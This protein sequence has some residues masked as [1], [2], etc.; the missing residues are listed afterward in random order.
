MS[1]QAQRSS[2]PRV[3]LLA[4]SL[5]DTLEAAGITVLDPFRVKDMMRAAS[6]GLNPHT[7]SRL[8]DEMVEAGAT[9]KYPVWTEF[10]YD[11]YCG[12]QP[13]YLNYGGSPPREVSEKIDK[14][15][16]LIP[17]TQVIVHTIPEDPY[18]EVVVGD[19]R[20]WVA[21]WSPAYQVCVV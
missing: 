9:P 19:E 2:A 13:T 6:F 17:D 15:R 10:D 5:R 8:L 4:L 21:G 11:V 18:V 12:D 3:A 20:C 14:I 7:S 1:T 16:E